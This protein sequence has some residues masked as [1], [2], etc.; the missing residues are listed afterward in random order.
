M[1]TPTKQVCESCEK[2]KNIETMVSDADANWF[3]QDCVKEINEERQIKVGDTIEWSFDD[4]EDVPDFL[5]N[6]SFKAKVLSVDKKNKEYNV[7]AEYGP[8]K[9]P[10]DEAKLINKTK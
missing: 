7:Y 9:I 6:N 2:E 10:F 8:D 4:S 5:R 3:C 1:E